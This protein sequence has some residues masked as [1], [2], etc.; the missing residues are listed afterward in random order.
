LLDD[1]SPK[2]RQQAVHTAMKFD[3]ARW[4]S[5]VHRRFWED[6]SDDVARTA[7]SSLEKVGALPKKEMLRIMEQSPSGDRRYVAASS[8][9][10]TPEDE[11]LLIRL[12]SDS[13]AYV[14]LC[15]TQG[16]GKIN[17]RLA[18]PQLV[19]LLA[20]EKEE[21]VIGSIL[22]RLG[23][24]GNRSV[25]PILIHWTDASDDHHRL[26]AIQSLIKLGDDRAIPIV[27]RMLKENRKPCVRLDHNGRMKTFNVL[28]M[29]VILPIC[30]RQSPNQALRDLAR[31]PWPWWVWIIVISLGIFLAEWIR[32]THGL[33][34]TGNKSGIRT[35]K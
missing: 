15:A 29:K 8:V 22:Q 34:V 20:K 33:P 7:F 23:E 21:D 31:K 2:V 30:L 16:L 3:S 6:P 5:L 4:A 26:D 18:V 12:L 1:P 28:P 35:N 25:V 17:A 24:L 9:E 32:S 10:W 11:G 27:K 13:H 19:D 14:R